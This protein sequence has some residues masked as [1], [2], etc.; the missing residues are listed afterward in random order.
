MSDGAYPDE[1]NFLNKNR[2]IFLRM[3]VGF[4]YRL[5]LF[6]NVTLPN[7]YLISIE[8]AKLRPGAL[9][10]SKPIKGGR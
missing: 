1:I 3:S 8:T 7:Q 5:E 2:P 9:K 6:S 4:A 10:R